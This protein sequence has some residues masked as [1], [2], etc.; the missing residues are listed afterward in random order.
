MVLLGKK[1]KTRKGSY[2]GTLIFILFYSFGLILSPFLFWSHTLANDLNAYVTVQTTP[3]GGGGGGGAGPTNP[4]TQVIIQGRAQPGSQVTILKDGS[5]ATVT[6]ADT[7]ANFKAEIINITPGIWTFTLWALDSQGRRSTSFAFT[8]NI[9]SGMTTTVSG[10][11]LPPT[12]SLDKNSLQKGEIL[13]IL[14]MTAPQSEITIYVNSNTEITKTTHAGADGV[15]LYKFDTSPLQEGDHNT[16]SKAKDNVGNLTTFSDTLT[17]SI[18]GQ[19]SAC[20]KNADINNDQRVNL[21][22]LSI[23]LYNWGKP[24]SSRADLD[25]DG[26]VNLRDFSIM[27]YWWTG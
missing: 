20:P 21:V 26:L 22:D 23:L 24:K 6:P 1:S 4:A 27:L 18:T 11:F 3:I 5:V 16:R 10:I 12:I 7:E 9:A 25:C 2:I 19:P 15:Y 13:N 14:G 8:T 17:F